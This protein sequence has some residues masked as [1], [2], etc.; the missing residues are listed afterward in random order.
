MQIVLVRQVGFGKNEP[1]DRGFY[2]NIKQSEHG[3]EK[4]QLLTHYQIRELL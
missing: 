1:S 3:I 2:R 4:L